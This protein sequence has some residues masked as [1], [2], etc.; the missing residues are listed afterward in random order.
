[1]KPFFSVI[2]A[3]RNGARTLERAIDSVLGQS[4]ADR[5]L[6]VVDDGSSDETPAVI[7]RYG[8][9]LRSHRQAN[10]GVSV[11]RNEG[12]R[13][14]RGNWLT[15]LDADDWYHPERLEAY[16]DL[17]ASEPGLD[18]LTGDFEYRTAEGRYLRRSMEATP[19]GRRLLEQARG[20][21]TAVMEGEAL[22]LFVE[23]HFG[24]T[25]TLTVPRETF[26]ALGG[27]PR[28]VAVC[29]DVNLLIRL[30]ARS[31]RVGVVCRPL[32]VYTVHAASATRA[33]PLRAQRETLAALL[34]LRAELA[35]APPGI[36]RGLEGCIR[37]A[38]LD[39]A[40]VLLR[41]GRRLEALRAVGPMLRERPG[42]RALRDVL[43]VARG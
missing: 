21:A 39:L 17:I 6:V 23:Q 8:E 31:R 7:G 34:P 4:Y 38:R 14:A 20:A 24:D 19:A 15:F 40:T 29:E 25:H 10:A 32:A 43:S 16:A 30:A 42:V 36:R 26:M 37:R 33:D 35:G 13:L 18:F 11:A 28:G 12:A 2:V 3:V 27:Y 9:R 5:E 41:G 22:G 1:M